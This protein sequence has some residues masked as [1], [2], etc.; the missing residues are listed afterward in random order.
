MREIILI[1]VSGRDCPGLTASLAEVLAQYNA[2]ILD[3]SQ[4]VIHDGL[5]LGLVVEIP[6]ESESS[7][8]LK[9]L[10]YRAHNLDVQLKFTP[11][12]EERY[13]EWVSVQGRQRHIVTILGRRISAR[14]LAMVS[15]VIFENGLNIDFMSRLSGRISFRRQ[16][17]RPRACMEISVRGTPLDRTAMRS[18]FMDISRNCGVD[19]AFQEDNAF[20]RNR[21]LVAF[22]MDSTLIE[23]EVIDELAKAAGVGA[24]VA[25]LTARAMQGEMDFRESL[26]R[27]VSLL[28]GLP[29]EVLGEVARTLPLTEG[30]ERVIR[31][32]K[33]LGYKLAIISGGFGYFGRLLQK[34]LDIDYVCANELEIEGGRLTGKIVGKIVDGARKAEILREIADKERIDLEQVIAV[35][36]GAND[37]PM[38]DIVGLGIAF[39]A[40]PVVK[41]GAGQSISH[42][43]LDGILYFLGIRDRDAF[44]GSEEP[45]GEGPP[46]L[47]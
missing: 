46:S 40:K 22:D 32:L 36:D 11:I 34:R 13:E 15:A 23:A 9:E 17:V 20:R 30:A 1:N 24:E 21:R 2:N 41:A 3:I 38:I 10:L 16:A 42:L 7:P 31:T 12:G 27:R 18:A 35:G 26:T 6:P 39:H 43:G 25:E 4:A 44:P 19:I 5:A 33:F 14:A 47:K 37:L 8:I 45:A 28:Q 29:A